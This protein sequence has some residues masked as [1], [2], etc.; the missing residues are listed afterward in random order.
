MEAVVAA[1]GLDAGLAILH[2]ELQGGT[3]LKFVGGEALVVTRPA[4]LADDPAAVPAQVK[5]VGEGLAGLAL[6]QRSRRG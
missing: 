4:E 6:N 5:R 2:E 1:Q 3:L